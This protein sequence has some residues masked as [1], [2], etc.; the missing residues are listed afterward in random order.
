MF[1]DSSEIPTDGYCYKF[2]GTDSFVVYSDTENTQYTLQ[3]NK[4][5]KTE[6]YDPTPPSSNEYC[7]TLQDFQHISS[8][9]G[10]LTPG[11]LVG[12]VLSFYVGFVIIL[13]ILKIGAP[14]Q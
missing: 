13:L 11:Y 8:P 10:Y 2:M 3:N 14:R 12:L 6:T 5:Y 1:V 4:L 9:I 7:Y